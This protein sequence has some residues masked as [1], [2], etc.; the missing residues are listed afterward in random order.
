MDNIKKHR[1]VNIHEYMPMLIDILKDGKD[2]N[3]LITGHSMSP[4]LRHKRDTIIISKPDGNFY[5]GQMV[6]YR[7]ENGQYVMHR[8]HHIKQDYL[9]M[10]GDHQVVIEG[11]INKQQVFGVVHKVIRNGKEYEINSNE[12]TIG[13]IL[14]L[15]SG[16][17]IA[18]DARIIE[19]HNFQVDESALTGESL[20]EVKNPMVLKE[21]TP[22][23]DI[24][25]NQP[26]KVLTKDEFID[27][28]VKQ[29][30]L[31]NPNVVVHRITGDPAKEDLIEPFWVLKKFVVLNDI[32][33]LMRKEKYY[34][35]DLWQK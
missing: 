26:F 3:L 23:G 32:D 7:R 24:Y 34:Q 22:L 4:F 28:S 1:E 2:V 11:P 25:L 21:D 31:L 12:V 16:D 19:C 6:F 27:I 30:R 5:R 9:Y 13:D 20:N 29:L 15:E 8:I 33:K 14:V 18:A 10:I 35:G 17:K